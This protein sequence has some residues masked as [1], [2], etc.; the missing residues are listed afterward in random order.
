MGCDG[1][2][3]PTRDE[4]IKTK[5][6]A[7]KVTFIRKFSILFKISLYHFHLIIQNPKD[8]EKAA[9]WNNCHLTQGPLQ[10]PIVADLLGKLVTF[11]QSF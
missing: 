4:L 8:I 3:I 2:T 9:K 1:G 7:I 5:K 11:F 10:Q 6:K